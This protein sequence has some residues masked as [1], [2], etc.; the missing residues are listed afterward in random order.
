MPSSKIGDSLHNLEIDPNRACFALSYG[1]AAELPRMPWSIVSHGIGEIVED[2][3][4]WYL[5]TW[6]FEVV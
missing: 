5:L 1:H 6:N 2:I 4:N 3:R